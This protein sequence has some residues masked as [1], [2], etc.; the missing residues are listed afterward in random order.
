MQ[1]QGTFALLERARSDFHGMKELNDDNG[2]TTQFE[3]LELEETRREPTA[4][5]INKGTREL[6]TMGPCLQ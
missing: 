6:Y 1:W 3:K 2:R 4:E 5:I